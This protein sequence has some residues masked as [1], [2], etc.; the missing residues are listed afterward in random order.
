[1]Y[2]LAVRTAGR[3]MN[4]YSP[5]MRIV[6]RLKNLIGVTGAHG[7]FRQNRLHTPSLQ[8]SRTSFLKNYSIIHLK[9][10]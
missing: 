1:M 9:H 4:L 2:F 6:G 3:L 7:D 8:Y 10:E 5:V